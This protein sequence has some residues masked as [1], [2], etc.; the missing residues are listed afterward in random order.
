[1]GFSGRMAAVNRRKVGGQIIY[2]ILHAGKVSPVATRPSRASNADFAY[3][4]SEFHAY[5]S[6]FPLFAYTG[7]RPWSQTSAATCLNPAADDV[8]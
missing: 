1:M 5:G 3:F 7:R 4:L 8:V 2:R 6:I